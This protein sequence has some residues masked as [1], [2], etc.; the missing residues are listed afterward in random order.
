M[1]TQQRF[2]MRQSL[3]VLRH[4]PSICL[5][6]LRKTTNLNKNLFRV[7]SQ[8]PPEYKSKGFMLQVDRP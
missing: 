4:Y 5:E 2:G 1:V 3:A 6:G 8:V 7:S